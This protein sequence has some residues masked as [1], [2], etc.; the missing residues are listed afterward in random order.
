MIWALTTPQH[1]AENPGTLR[2]VGH[3]PPQGPPCQIRGC[4][5]RGPAP[6][7]TSKAVDFETA[8]PGLLTCNV[9]VLDYSRSATDWNPDMFRHCYAG[10]RSS[11]MEK[12]GFA[13]RQRGGEKHT[14]HLR[15]WGTRGTTAKPRSHTNVVTAPNGLMLTRPPISV[16]FPLGLR[17]AEHAK[18]D[19]AP[20]KGKFQTPPQ[21]PIGAKGRLRG[22]QREDYDRKPVV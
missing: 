6:V 12:N 8:P 22:S 17:S 11:A 2:F 9:L 21:F 3:S 20:A 10:V 14:S 16:A 18:F 7:T 5:R 13:T 15:P 19:F 1:G 4:E